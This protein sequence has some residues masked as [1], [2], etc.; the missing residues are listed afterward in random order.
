M[1]YYIETTSHANIES[2][3]WI[4]LSDLNLDFILDTIYDMILSEKILH[5]TTITS[6]Y[7]LNNIVSNT[8]INE[9][10]INQRK[11]RSYSAVSDEMNVNA[12]PIDSDAEN[13]DLGLDLGLAN[14]NKNTIINSTTTTTAQQAL[15]MIETISLLDEILEKSIK[16][17][18]NELLEDELDKIYMVMK[19][20]VNSITDELF[21]KSVQHIV[22]VILYCIIYIQIF[23]II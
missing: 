1:H 15:I 10:N 12:S 19:Y 5:L 9:D 14:V 18:S 17:L 22:M 2:S 16:L 13:N 20:I 8:L 3:K 23:I 11:I 21:Q 7:E 4:D 6:N